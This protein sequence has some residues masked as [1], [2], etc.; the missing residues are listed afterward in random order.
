MLSASSATDLHIISI[1]A[2]GIESLTLNKCSNDYSFA[3]AFIY[4]ATYSPSIFTAA[5]SN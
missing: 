2:S 4:D 5:V 3:I 1:K